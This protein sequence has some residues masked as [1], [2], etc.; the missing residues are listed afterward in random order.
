MMRGVPHA[1]S[2]A[3]SHRSAGCLRHHATRRFGIDPASSCFAVGAASLGARRCA[4]CE[5]RDE[6]VA[7]E[8]RLR[9][10]APRPWCPAANTPAHGR[11]GHPTP[12]CLYQG[13][14]I[15]PGPAAARRDG[16]DGRRSIPASVGGGGGGPL[17]SCD[18]QPSP[19]GAS[20]GCRR[21][22]RDD[23]I[24]QADPRNA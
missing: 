2:G 17:R 16:E 24:A 15:G 4:W 9:V 21:S 13:T 5:R 7:E 23:T 6:A 18:V 11:R 1:L 10:R 19:A 12:R 20:L 14:R 22:Q 3:R 8:G